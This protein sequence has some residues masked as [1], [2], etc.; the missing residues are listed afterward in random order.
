ME[1]LVLQGVNFLIS[2]ADKYNWL[3]YVLM[4]IGGL[5]VLLGFSRAFLTCLVKFTKTKK[6]NE[7]LLSVYAFLDKYGW[8]FGPLAD[9]YEKKVKEIEEKK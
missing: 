2:I 9:Y 7:I 5:Y 1:E 3:S 6:D 8:G 4:A